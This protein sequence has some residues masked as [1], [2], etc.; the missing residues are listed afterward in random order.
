MLN[1]DTEGIFAGFV[2]F[3]MISRDSVLL[4][5]PSRP[6]AKNTISAFMKEG[7]VIAHNATENDSIRLWKVTVLKVRAVATS[8]HFKKNYTFQEVINVAVWRFNTTF[9]TL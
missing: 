1:E 4:M 8:L 9:V 3:K 6:L 7:I 5:D 2:V